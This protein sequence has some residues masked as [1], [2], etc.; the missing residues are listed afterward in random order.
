MSNDFGF[1]FVED[2]SEKLQNEAEFYKANMK[3]IVSKIMPLL[4]NLAKDPSKDIHWPNR[5]VVM[6]KFIKEINDIVKQEIK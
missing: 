5:D 3:L 1:S 2:P 6:K 4:E